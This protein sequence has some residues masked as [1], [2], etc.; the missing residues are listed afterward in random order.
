MSVFENIFDVIEE[1]GNF[2]FFSDEIKTLYYYNVFK[3]TNKNILIVTSTL[4]EAQQLYNS[5]KNYINE[6]NLFL[7]DDFL[8]SIAVSISP[9]LEIA[10]LELLNKLSENK[11]NIIITNLMGYLRPLDNPLSFNNKKLNLKVQDQISKDNLI[12]SLHNLGYKKETYVSKTGD[13]AIRGYVV[14]VFLLNNDNPIRIEF[15]GDGIE[16]IKYF[17]INTQLSTQETKEINILPIKENSNLEIKETSTITDYLNEVLTIFN[18]YDYLIESYR[19]TLEEV[20]NYNKSINSNKEYFKKI[21]EIKNMPNIKI[22]PFKNKL[23]DGKEVEIPKSK[24]EIIKLLKKHKTIIFCLKDI[25]KINKLTNF[26]ELKTFKI[27]NENNIIDNEINI[28]IKQISKSF[29]IKNYFFVS[30]KDLFEENHTTKYKTNFKIGNKINNINN[31]KKG[32]YIVHQIYGIGLYKGIK[33][34]E[35]NN[36]IKDY[37]YVEYAGKDKLYVPVENIEFITKYSSNEHI[38][39]V[40]NKLKSSEWSKTIAKTKKRVQELAIDLLK[41]YSQREVEQGFAFSENSE[42]QKSFEEDFEYQE[43]YDQIKVIEEVNKDMENPKPMDR[44]V[45]GDVGF[46]KTEIAFRAAFKCVVDNKQVM[47]LC[48]TTILSMQHYKNALKRFENFPVKIALLNRFVSTKEVNRIINEIKENKIDIVIG[49]HKLLNS[50]ITYKDLGLL[51]IDEEQRF[52]VKH[53]EYIKNLKKNIDV[54]SL[55]ATPIPRTLQMSLSGIRELST[56]ETAPLNRNPIQTYV[57]EENLYLIK[58][59]IYKEVSRNG[60][61]Y[62]LFN[63]VE[64]MELKK[65]EIEKELKNIKIGIAHGRM[66]KTEIEK[67]MKD[68]DE[69]KYDVLLCTTIIETGIDIPNVNTIIILDSDKLGLSQLYQIRGRV[70]RSEKI[71]YCYLMFQKNKFLSSIARARLE[72]IK[73][74]TQLG[75]GLLIAKKDL[76]LRGAGDILGSEQSGFID[77]VGIELFLE[78]LNK[79]INKLKGIDEKEKELK[80]SFINVSTNISDSYIENEEIKLYMHKRINEINSFE[81]LNET[82]Q[83]LIDRFGKISEDLIIYMYEELFEKK[84]I[85]LN[86]KRIE[87][88]NQNILIYLPKELLKN[89]KVLDLMYDLNKINNNIKIKEK[90]K[91]IIIDFKINNLD[92]HFI[93]YLIDIIEV[94]NKQND[95]IKN[96]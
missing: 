40:L 28:I 60:Q 52:G 3:K 85:E 51:I 58:D 68:F 89:I 19:Q 17:D 4:Y 5:L 92:K 46:G 87:Q 36:L 33:T 35:T 76:A 95:I 37:L 66:N 13:F 16:T 10:R 41:V 69:R 86:L 91:N 43:T 49:T 6:V 48:P 11:K 9:E 23:S 55:T 78:L 57:L 18:D 27:T 53:K 14:D 32:D 93:Y 83:E 94:L 47:F 63:S 7:M 22:Q 71:A 56:L 88:T 25:K 54:L 29:K 79:E 65:Q 34:L 50:N 96:T 77:S 67:I 72:T 44:L 42:L 12:E 74:F 62:I 39:P 75:S 38:V 81:K 73:E 70:G 30:D 59:A 15:W 21:D 45:C 82:K 90:S 84:A 80:T 61:V 2:S 26:L 8:T 20:S 64:N 31:L 24:E 1:D